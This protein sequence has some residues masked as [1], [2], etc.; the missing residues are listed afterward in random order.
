FSLCYL[1]PRKG[2][3]IVACPDGGTSIEDL[4]ESN[5]E[6]ILKEEVDIM[7]GLTDAQAGKIAE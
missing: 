1:R 7:T 2:P 3:V 4:A 5:P 6:L